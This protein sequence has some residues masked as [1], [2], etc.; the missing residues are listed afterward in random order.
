MCTVTDMQKL[1]LSLKKDADN[2]RKYS[3]ELAKQFEAVAR[4]IFK[5]FGTP[6][7]FCGPR[8]VPAGEQN[9]SP[10]PTERPRVVVSAGTHKTLMTVAEPVPEVPQPRQATEIMGEQE[11]LDL[12]IEDLHDILHRMKATAISVDSPGENKPKGRAR[13]TRLGGLLGE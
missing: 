7:I 2:Y 4:D 12:A 13:R 10:T 8:P 6:D 1:A 11:E 5:Q 9:R 3:E